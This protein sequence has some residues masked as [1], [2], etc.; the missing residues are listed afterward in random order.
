MVSAH[1]AVSRVR[2]RG[3]LKG[4]KENNIQQSYVRSKETETGHSLM[5]TRRE[6]NRSR[7]YHNGSATHVR[8]LD[9]C[10]AGDCF[11]VR[12]EE[13][14]VEAGRSIACGGLVVSI[15]VFISFIEID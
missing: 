6:P 12:L 3:T 1:P 15:P 14:S 10:V 9:A 5:N 7:H 8:R 4:T 13:Q 2:F 11:E